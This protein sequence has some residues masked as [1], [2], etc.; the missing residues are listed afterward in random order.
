MWNCGLCDDGALIWELFER[1]IL[2]VVT[3]AVLDAIFERPW[4][5]GK[6][7]AWESTQQRFQTSNLAADL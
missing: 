6:K 5:R 3:N 2:E 1:T 7:E 4:M